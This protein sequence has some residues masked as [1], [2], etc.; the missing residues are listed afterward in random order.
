MNFMVFKMVI[1]VHYWHVSPYM[2]CMIAAFVISYIIIFALLKKHNVEG[3]I[4]GL[5]LL[6]NIVF[7]GIGGK[8]YTFIFS[9]KCVIPQLY[10]SNFLNICAIPFS[11][12][13]AMFGM[14]VSIV[15]F[16]YINGTD[17]KL[18]WKA[19]ALQLPLLYS[20]SKIGCLLMGCC[21]G[22]SYEGIL[23]V[24]YKAADG[25]VTFAIPEFNVFPVQLCETI[26]FAIIFA[27]FLR[28]YIAKDN[29]SVEMLCV[30]C[31][32]TKGLLEILREEHIGHILNINQIFCLLVM[33]GAIAVFGFRKVK[34]FK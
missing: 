24:T 22:I 12:M 23:K 5:S 21:H 10:D 28:M 25:E 20:I 34:Y 32:I 15:G 3:R 13:G 33:C 14:L 6:M 8:L 11:S 26:A 18:F 1:T 29:Y 16:N 7:I 9:Y 4:I 17:S 31:A 2:V 30:I 19:Y 27:I